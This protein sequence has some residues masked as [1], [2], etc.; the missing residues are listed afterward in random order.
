MDRLED[1]GALADVSGRCDAEAADEAG[2]QIGE[3]VAVQIRHYENIVLRW[4]LDHLKARARFSTAQ[5]H[6]H[7]PSSELKKKTH[8]EANRI[9]IRFLKRVNYLSLIVYFD[10]RN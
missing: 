8:I 3:N 4:I 5:A 10:C 9:E 7:S 6:R 1:G 2:A